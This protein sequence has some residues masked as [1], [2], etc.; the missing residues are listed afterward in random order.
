VKQS[1]IGDWN[2]L[3]QGSAG[4]P[5]ANLDDGVVLRFFS[6]SST[7]NFYQIVNGVTEIQLNTQA[8]FRDP[9]AWYHIVVQVDTT[10]ATP[11]NRVKIY[12]NGVE[13]VF[14]TVTYPTQD[15][16]TYANTTNLHTIGALVRDA[17]PPQDFH[18]GYLADIHFIDGQA[19][20]PTSFGEFDEDTGVWVPKAYTGTYGTN[21]FQLKF[22]DNSNN[23]ATTLGKD[24]SPNGNN[25]TP[26]NL[27]I[28]AGAGNDSLI[29][30][31]TN[32]AQTDTGAGGEVRGNYA[33]MNPLPNTSGN[34][35][36]SNGNLDYSGTQ[37][38]TYAL[39][40][41]TIGVSSGKW[42]W[43]V[44][45]GT[46]GP[47]LGIGVF[48]LSNAVNYS[49]AI[50]GGGGTDGG[51]AFYHGIANRIYYYNGSAQV[52]TSYT[53]AACTTG[54]VVSVAL[55]LDNG[56][57]YFAKNGSWGASGNP[58]TQSNP[59]LTGLQGTYAAG[60]SIGAF[61]TSNATFNFG[62][63]PWAYPAPSG[64]KALNT[65][66][67]PAPTITNPSDVFD[68][69]LYTGTGATQSITGLGFSP[70]LLW[71]K[72]R[73]ASAG[74]ALNDSVRGATKSLSSD[75]TDAEYTSSAGNDLVSF[76]SDGFTV[77]PTE[78]WN[79]YNV[80][81]G[82][83]VAWAW[84]AGSSTVTNTDG[85]ISCQ[86]RANAS[87]GFSVVTY[88]VSASDRTVGHGLGVPVSIS[89]VKKRNGTSD[90][91]FRY[92]L[93]GGL[94]GYMLLNS[95]AG[96]TSS[97]SSTSTTVSAGYLGGT[98]DW[99]MYNFAP[100][101][102]YSSFGS[103]TGNGS[104]DGPFVYTNGF[105]PRLVMVKC[106]SSDQGG[107][108]VWSL[109]DTARSQYNVA[110]NRLQAQSSGA[111]VTDSQWMDINSNGFKIR[112]TSSSVNANGATYIYAAWAESPFALNNRAR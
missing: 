48:R 21:G 92:A 13:V 100:V 61:G 27:S 62:Q 56:K 104:T 23:T 9:S 31:P 10:Q 29:D 17:G 78:V 73:D 106:S 55:D 81:G 4:N 12:I 38:A 80:S 7:L 37:G 68:V 45:I 36:L 69:K 57:I 41:S 54:D 112:E 110:I 66:N 28:T 74:H 84:D 102:G 20:D 91:Y 94:N 50:T 24:T 30:V 98:E 103:Y 107:N 19:L 86:V 35:V 63:R 25:W 3:F 51:I 33:T 14:F 77:G 42:Y 76:N 40:G 58:A 67:L 52:F 22:A 96:G 93:P 87:A 83:L 89:L 105:R 15:L 70:D 72:R 99:V 2:V 44:T 26:N 34:A 46:T 79:S 59:A 82:S 47:N 97:F 43:E 49:S 5:T 1:K 18:N 85:N 64:F 88:T 6:G 39:S 60:I 75:R 90:W 11:S 65:A 71:F 16:L 95:T 108:A 53:L 101:A 32:G 8:A 109:L 111:E